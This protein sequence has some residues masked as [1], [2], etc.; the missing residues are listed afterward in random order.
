MNSLCLVYMGGTLGCIGQPL[1]PLPAPIFLAK[2]KQLLQQQLQRDDL[3]YC[4]APIIRDSTALHGADWLQLIAFLQNLKQQGASH[5]LLIHGTD[6]LSYAAAVLSRFLGTSLHIVITGSQVPLW[7]A[8]GQ[9]LHPHSDALANLE[10]ALAQL[11]HS[12]AGCYVAFAGQL[13]EGRAS[14]KLQRNAWQAFAEVSQARN[15]L[16]N[17]TKKPQPVASALHIDA[18]T[19]QLAESLSIVNLMLQPIHP[20]ALITQLQNLLTNA[21][22]FLILQGY[23]CGN[24]ALNSEL[25]SI[26][27]QLNT[28]GCLCI[29]SSQVLFGELDN[30]Y[31]VNGDVTAAGL[32]MDNSRSPADLYAKLLQMYLQYPTVAE[33]RQHWS[34]FDA[35]DAL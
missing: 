3:S 17:N 6:T 24:I 34:T 2:L 27:Q 18:A 35:D 21:P 1:A 33:W 16:S 4:A 22:H 29:L 31:A 26:L 28:Q 25:S 30:V 12:Q 14:I 7:D 23:G 5:I 10:F 11:Q 20:N 32:V 19:L 8:S 13:I 9:D 15:D